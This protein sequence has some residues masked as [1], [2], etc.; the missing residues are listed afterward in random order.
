[1]NSRK[2]NRITPLYVNFGTEGASLVLRDDETGETIETPPG[3]VE[4]AHRP[5]WVPKVEV[6]PITEWSKRH[7]TKVVIFSAED[8]QKQDKSLLWDALGWR[9][10]V[11]VD[12]VVM[13]MLVS[14]FVP[15]GTILVLDRAVP[16]HNEWVADA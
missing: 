9:P 4:M 14:V 12:G 15:K 7:P 13:E 8:V 10:C 16:S 11:T 5:A 6:A 1:M 3:P 2:I